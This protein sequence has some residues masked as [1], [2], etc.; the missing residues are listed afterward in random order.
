[1]RVALTELAI[2]SALHK[3]MSTLYS[4]K[5]EVI[6]LH[7]RSMPYAVWLP[8]DYSLEK[9]WPVLLFLHGAGERGT[10]GLLQTTVGIG[11]ALKNAPEKFPFLVILPQCPRGLYWDVLEEHLLEA[12][13]FASRK[14]VGDSARTYLTGVSMG[15]YG[16]WGLGSLHPDL[17]SALIPVCGGGEPEVMAQPLSN[18]PIWAFHGAKDDIVPVEESRF[19]VEAVEKAGNPRIRYTEY[20]KGTHNVWDATYQEPELVPWL[21]SQTK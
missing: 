13:K 6:T 14:F 21:L 2:N 19:M 11:P 12:L 16:T 4:F 10:D 9:A 15:G 18:M 7:G 8:P 3:P 5:T 20:P 17:F 1:M